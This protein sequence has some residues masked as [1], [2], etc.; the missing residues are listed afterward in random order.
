[1]PRKLNLDRYQRQ[2]LVSQIGPTGQAKIAVSRALVVGMGALGCTIAD[3]LARAGVAM[4]RIVDRDVVEW[5]N[6]QRQT[7]YDESDARRSLPKVE[8]AARRLRTIRTDLRLDPHAIDVDASNVESLARD[9][10]LILDGSDNAE[11]RYLINDVSVK[12]G[13]PWVMGGCLGVEGRVAAF[14]PK[15]G[16]PCLRCLFPTPPGAGEL[17]TCDT[18]GALGP[19]IGVVASMQV[20]EA[21]KL[22]LGDATAAGRLHKIDVWAGRQ[23]SVDLADAKR[24]DCSCCGAR[25]FE[26][27]DRPT[28]GGAKLCGRNAVQVR[29]ATA[30]RVDLAALA[31]R[32]APVATLDATSLML[33]VELRERPEQWLSIFGDGRAIVFGTAD[34]SVARALYAR[35]IGT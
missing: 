11:L 22:V 26:F 10:D 33:K 24:I 12:S 5:T 4:L 30:T 28:T 34:L 6:L 21:M 15:H 23:H 18:A 32:L 16:R 8:A 27:L 9:V 7:L 35:V 3:Q 17:A 2:S 20:V 31:E 19:A 29:P 25:K 13:V 1:V 14:N